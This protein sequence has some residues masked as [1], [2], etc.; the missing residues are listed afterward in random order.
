MSSSELN[1]PIYIRSKQL[2][3]RF[4]VSPM[5][6]H[7]RMAEAHLA[8]RLLQQYRHKTDKPTPL[9]NVRY[10]VNS[11]KHLLAASISGFDPTETL[12]V[13]CATVLKPVSALSE[14][15]F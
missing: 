6:L 12:A 5:W 8:K 7:R 13:H 9:L 14:Y 3:A 10:R 2:C 4:G 11:G 1:Q 15:S